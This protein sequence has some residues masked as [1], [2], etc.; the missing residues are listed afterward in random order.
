MIGAEQLPI[1]F[2]AENAHSGS[3]APQSAVVAANA[4]AALGHRADLVLHRASGSLLAEVSPE[5]RVIAL[6]GRPSWS[7]VRALLGVAGPALFARSLAWR[8]PADWIYWSLPELIVYLA[9]IRPRLLVAF[10]MKVGSVNGMLA[11]LR[12]SP[13]TRHVS[14]MSIQASAW[15]AQR[16]RGKRGLVNWY[17]ECD[18]I[19]GCSEGVARDAERTL[20]LAP[21]SIF[22]LFEPVFD[23]FEAPSAPPRH[24]WLAEPGRGAGRTPVIVSAGRLIPRKDYPTLL[25]AFARLRA[26]RPA[27]LVIFGEGPLE[28][29]LTA[30]ARILGVGD[31]LDL[32]GHHADLV[33]EFAGA[34]LFAFASRAEGLGKV[35]VEALAAGLPVACTDCPSGPREI[36]GDGRYGTL[37]PVGNAE[38]L[39]AAMAAELDAPRPRAVQIERAREFSARVF[40][41]R[42][43]GRFDL[44]QPV[45]PS[46]PISAIG[47]LS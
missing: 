36:L 26:G 5:V 34:D 25:R 33:R 19:F 3:G 43:L 30:Q 46:P 45:G 12:P 14:A 4:C 35:I 17:R 27:R 44:A 29:E 47:D 22:S 1:A 23:T 7:A 39:A 8:R 9:S 40:V 10:G 41:E 13:A 32:P 42:L 2:L 16:R 11:R 31:D 21:S 28:R 38:R 37:V 18:A 15:I 24:R 20:G 6:D